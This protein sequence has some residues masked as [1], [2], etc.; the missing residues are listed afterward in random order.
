MKPIHLSPAHK[1]TRD[2]GRLGQHPQCNGSLS[3]STHSLKH[4]EDTGEKANAQYVRICGS[5]AFS[6]GM[7]YPKQLVCVCVCAC[8]HACVCVCVSVCVFSTETVSISFWRHHLKSWGQVPLVLLNVWI[9][10]RPHLVCKGQFSQT[11]GG[12]GVR[13][14]QCVCL[15]ALCWNIMFIK[16][17]LLGTD[18]TGNI[19]ILLL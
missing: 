19:A 5:E 8:V 7:V 12:I 13:R 14:I 3:E 1:H 15:S 16:R 9:W 11:N 10:R 2:A 17:T 6:S 4:W 18:G